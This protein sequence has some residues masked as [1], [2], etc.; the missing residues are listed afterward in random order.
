MENNDFDW[1]EIEEIF[2]EEEEEKLEL[3]FK[4]LFRFIFCI[5]FG[6]IHVWNTINLL[7]LLIGDK[8]PE[9]T[10]IGTKETVQFIFLLLITVFVPFF[11]FSFYY[12]YRIYKNGLLYKNPVN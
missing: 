12:S 2:E 6:I 3:S 10:I 5:F 11:L 9:Q 7:I 1:E 4:W 8:I